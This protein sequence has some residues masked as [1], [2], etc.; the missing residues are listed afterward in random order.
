VDFP[1]V[2]N[3]PFGVGGVVDGEGAAGGFIV[4]VEDAEGCVG[5]GVV[6]VERVV[7]VA[8]EVERSVEGSR[9]GL[10]FRPEAIEIETQLEGVCAESLGEVVGDGR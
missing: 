3:E 2:L 5:E 7:D 9:G 8:V 1:G 4:L 10:V 6:G